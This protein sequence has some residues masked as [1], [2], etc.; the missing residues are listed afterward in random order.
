[1]VVVVVGA[2]AAGVTSIEVDVVDVVGEGT[3]TPDD[4]KETTPN[5]EVRVGPL[6]W[7]WGI[8]MIAKI[9]RLTR[10]RET[11]HHTFCGDRFTFW[12][13]TSTILKGD[14]RTSKYTANRHQCLLKLRPDTSTAE[15]Q[16]N[17]QKHEIWSEE[18]S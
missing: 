5:D 18:S 7:L 12:D 17:R 3:T 15:F 1:M 6:G 2:D 8:N 11:A 10:A 14:H 16:Q 9:P 4:G 13:F